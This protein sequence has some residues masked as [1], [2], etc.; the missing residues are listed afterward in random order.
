MPLYPYACDACGHEFEKVVPAAAVGPAVTCPNCGG[1]N[2]TRG[3]GLPA[4]A[5]KPLPATNCRGDGPPC[6]A[7]GCGRMPRR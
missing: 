3:F 6:G 5:A 4:V 1:P 7:V 2:V